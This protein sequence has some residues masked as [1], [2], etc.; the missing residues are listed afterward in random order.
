[1]F[2][3]ANWCFP[4]TEIPEKLAKI[5]HRLYEKIV[6]GLA[7]NEKWRQVYVTVKEHRLHYSDRSLTNFAKSMSLAKVIRHSSF[8]GSEQL[9]VDIVD[10]MLNS[11]A[12]LE[13]GMSSVFL[14]I[15]FLIDSL[16]HL[17]QRYKWY[18]Y[19]TICLFSV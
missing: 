16:A 9:L 3:N 10:C 4:Y 2:L 17:N 13:K 14:F 8:Q 5:P 19:I 12:E 15:C 6:Q 7:A 11:G 1:M 18:F